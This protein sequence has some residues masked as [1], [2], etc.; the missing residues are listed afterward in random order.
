MRLQ[1]ITVKEL[2]RYYKTQLSMD[3]RIYLSHGVNRFQNQVTFLDAY[4]NL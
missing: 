4:L 1:D 2:L 3:I